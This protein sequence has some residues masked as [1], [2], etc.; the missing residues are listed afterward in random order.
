[1]ADSK[2]KQK[3]TTTIVAQPIPE[4][5]LATIMALHQRRL[6]WAYL[7]EAT[8]TDR[9][10]GFPCEN[11]EFAIRRELKNI[12]QKISE[13]FKTMGSQNNWPSIRGWIWEIDFASGK[14]I[15]KKQHS[16]TN[17]I[18]SEQKDSN[19]NLL[20]EG[21]I[22][23]LGDRDLD[24]IKRLLEKR[25]ALADFV[26]SHLRLLLNGNFTKDELNDTV[27]Q[28]GAAEKDVKN[29]FSE[30]AT[31]YKWPRTED[32]VWVYRVDISEKQVYLTRMGKCTCSI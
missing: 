13:W 12:F 32:T 10:V 6:G 24:I 25:E 31:A 9:M 26:R 11:E 7:L 23:S 22:M 20:V 18:E 17:K 15:P 30:M 8:I 4:V 3:T 27:Q 1:M 5:D 19:S 2:N 29:W 28:L 21:P 16:Q 14:A